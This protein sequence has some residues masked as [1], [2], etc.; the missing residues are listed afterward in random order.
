MMSAFGLIPLTTFRRIVEARN[1]EPIII[2]RFLLILFDVPERPEVGADMIEDAVYDLSHPHRVGFLYQLQKFFIGGSPFPRRRIVWIFLGHNLKV[3]LRVGTEVAVYVSVV[4]GIVFVEGRRFKQ[5]IEINRVDAKLMEVWQSI[6]HAF[7]IAAVST[8]EN[9]II[10]ITRYLFLPRLQV[11]PVARPGRD[12]PVGIRH[13]GVFG[14][15]IVLRKAYP[16]V[17]ASAT[18]VIVTAAATNEEFQNQSRNW[19]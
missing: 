7:E 10:E 14:G 2:G 15:P 8:V 19:V 3:A 17:E 18:P 16:A 13:F 6:H 1:V 4:G 5:R 9:N 12:A 11:V